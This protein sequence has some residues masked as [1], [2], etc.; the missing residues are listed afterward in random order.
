M[1]IEKVVRNNVACAVIHSED[2]VIT[3]ISSALDLLM[4][5]KYEAGTKNRVY[6]IFCVKSITWCKAGQNMN[7][8][9]G[10]I[11]HPLSTV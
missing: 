5:V 3:D 7:D 10:G 6:P 2:K 1:T 11:A 8:S 4:S 9:G